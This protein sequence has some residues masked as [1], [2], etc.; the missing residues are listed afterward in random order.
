[1]TDSVLG[2]RDVFHV[3]VCVRHCATAASKQYISHGAFDL[4]VVEAGGLTYASFQSL[5]QRRHRRY[6]PLV[7]DSGFGFDFGFGFG[8]GFGVVFYLALALGSVFVCSLYG[9]FLARSHEKAAVAVRTYLFR[10]KEE[11]S[12]EGIEPDRLLPWRMHTVLVCPARCDADRGTIARFVASDLKF[13]E[14]NTVND[15]ERKGYARS[16]LLERFG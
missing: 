6:R 3:F 14:D 16:F 13:N 11:A 1:M 8:F 15:G 2:G 7:I 9:V 5:S 4:G 12:G 10:R